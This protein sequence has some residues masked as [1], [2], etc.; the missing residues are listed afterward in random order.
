M[1]VT[2][3]YLTD[4]GE[5]NPELDHTAPGVGSNVPFELCLHW[6]RPYSAVD[7]TTVYIINEQDQCGE[8]TFPS[9]WADAALA[10]VATQRMTVTVGDCASQGY[11]E[12][13]G[14]QTVPGTGAPSDPV[15]NL[16]TRATTTV[17]IINEQ[18]QCGESTFP[19]AW[20]DAALAWVATQRMTVAVGD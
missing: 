10:W 3:S 2:L 12:A 4:T 6:I 1:L 13:A 18:D 16:F 5:T 17:Y 20:A 8:S 7:T 19:S 14:S 11:T 9:A 15:V